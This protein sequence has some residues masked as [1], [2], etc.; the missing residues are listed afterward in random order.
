M[1]GSFQIYNLSFRTY[2]NCKLGD[3]LSNSAIVIMCMIQCRY[4]VLEQQ[5]RSLPLLHLSLISLGSL[6]TE[7]NP[8]SW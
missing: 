7:V 5:S 3:I 2:S 4:I 1:N 6:C 8:H